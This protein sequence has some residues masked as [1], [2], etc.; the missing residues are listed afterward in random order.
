LRAIIEGRI[1]DTKKASLISWDSM[2]GPSNWHH[3][4]EELYRTKKGSWFLYGVGGPA[5]KYAKR[6]GT[7]WTGGSAIKPLRSSEAL[8]W[9]EVAGDV[10]AVEEYFLAEITEA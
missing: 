3:W 4:R 7:G 10:D 2:H 9:L 8:T 6:E 5:S 1:Y